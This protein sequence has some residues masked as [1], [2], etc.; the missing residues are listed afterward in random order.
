[1]IDLSGEQVIEHIHGGREQDADV[2][3]ASTPTENLSQEG[4][5]HARIADDNHAGTLLQEVQLEQAKD[6]VFSLLAR[7]VMGEVELVE[8]RLSRQA[9]EFEATLDRKST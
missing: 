1:M 5:S 6:A 3:L 9:R 4:F 2:R 7:F 8:G